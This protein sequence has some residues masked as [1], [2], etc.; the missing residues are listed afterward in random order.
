MARRPSST[1]STSA[2]SPTPTVTASATSPASPTGCPTSATSGVD[3]VWITPFYRS[4][5]RD[6]GYDVADYSDVDPM[7]GTLDDADALIARA[8]D[9]GLRVIVD[10]VPN[11]TSSEHPWFQEALAAE[12]GSHA[13]ARYLFR[14]GRAGGERAAQQLG[15]GV[16]RAGLDPGRRHRPVVPPP[17]RPDPAR[18]GL[19]APRRGRAVRR[20]AAVLAGPRRRRVPDRRRPRPGEGRGPAGTSVITPAEQLPPRTPARMVGAAHRRR[21]DVGPAR[22]ARD[23]PR[24]APDPRRVRRR[25]D[26]RRRGLDPDP[27][28]DG[29]LR[30][31]RRAAPGVQLPLAGGRVVGAGLGRV[32]EETLAALGEVGGEPTWVLS[33]HDVSR[34][35]RGTAA[36]RSAW[37]APGRRRWC[38]WRCPARRTSTRA[39]SW[40]SRTSTSRPEHRQDPS[41]FR[42][43]K[44]GRDGC[45]VPIPWAGDRPPYGFGPGAAQPWIPQPVD[46]A[47]AH[48]RGPGGRPGLDA[49][50]LPP[51]AGGPARAR[52]RAR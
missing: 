36:A 41:W 23:L 2:A 15:L 9:L 14:T 13:R 32:V 1:R 21:A 4:P 8:H 26:G 7:F 11:H 43:G 45:R 28:G 19:A 35:A 24:L 18:P 20:R 38:R 48:R 40:A 39:R 46:W 27:G 47:P 5:Q 17:L 49:E 6:H 25:P 44:P 29:A 51:G 52:R 50:L 33:N 22:G 3:A 12:P 37:P 30:A 31:R 42:T 16:R 34:H 10:L